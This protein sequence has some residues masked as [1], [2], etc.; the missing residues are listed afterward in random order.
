MKS[1]V[2]ELISLVHS[3]IAYI[4]TYVKKIFRALYLKC[5][6][7]SKGSGI[8]MVGSIL[9]LRFLCPA[10]ATPDIFGITHSEMTTDHQRGLI[11]VIKIFQNIVNGVEFNGEKEVF[12]MCMNDMVQTYHEQIKLDISYLVDIVPSTSGKNADKNLH[13]QKKCPYEK[14]TSSAEAFICVCKY[15]MDYADVAIEKLETTES[16][17]S[18]RSMIPVAGECQPIPLSRESSWSDSD[19]ASL[20]D[21]SDF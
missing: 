7:F 11:Y 18:L 6:T 9:F 8:T 20:S 21:S 12:M 10:L 16:K 15:Y 1:L 19:T 2:K 5:E 4:S 3:N 13:K 14:A 17:A